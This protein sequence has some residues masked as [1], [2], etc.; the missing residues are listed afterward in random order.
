MRL[1]EFA[2]ITAHAMDA[3]CDQI[4]VLRTENTQGWLVFGFQTTTIG[5]QMKTT[6]SLRWFRL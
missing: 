4:R 5:F 6:V 3:P 2:A 1:D